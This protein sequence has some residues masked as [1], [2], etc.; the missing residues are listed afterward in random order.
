MRLSVLFVLTALILASCGGGSS[1][2]TQ[3]PIGPQ[4]QPPPSAPPTT[5]PRAR[6]SAVRSATDW[7]YW[8][9]SP[10][11]QSPTGGIVIGPGIVATELNEDN[12]HD[13]I[14][15][16]AH[17]G[18][19]TGYG[20]FRNGV[21]R[22]QMFTYLSEDAAYQ[23]GRLLR[24]GNEPPTV[25]VATGA[26]AG[27]IA[28]TRAVVGLINSALPQRWQL[29]FSSQ[30]VPAAESPQNGGIVV[31]FS[32]ARTWPHRHDDNTLGLADW[33]YES[34]GEITA[35]RVW[36]DPARNRTQ[37]QRM[38]VLAHEMLHALGRGHAD[39][40]RFP[41]TITHESLND[42]RHVKG[43][44]LH[45]LDNEALLAV[46]SRMRPGTP[47]HL[48]SRDL[49]PWESESFNV[50]AV[51]PPLYGGD[52]DDLDAHLPGLVMFGASERN[53]AVRPWALGHPFPDA[54][55]ANSRLTGSATWTGRL[56][57]LTTRSEPLAGAAGMTID[58][59][60]LQGDLSFSGLETWGENR[61]P[62]AI[63]TGARWGDGDLD[64]EIQVRGNGFHRVAG[65]GSDTGRVEGVFVGRTHERM[66]GIVDRYDM[67][68]GFGGTRQ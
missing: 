29:R 54:T 68:A 15:G 44:I 63:G 47:A 67:S 2:L 9:N 27:Q 33:Q 60:T 18:F 19:V 13:I 14:D 12:A 58:I 1:S 59:A 25:Y 43:Y 28:E 50:L 40:R 66:V 6:Y 61:P 20:R 31:R 65:S 62:G 34:T 41:Y 3:R 24:W 11:M 55:L 22:F 5:V 38:E 35:A 16:P 51:A 39:A 49:G 37:Q 10:I 53:G 42:E 8:W 52:P 45:Q 64:Y 17:D 46:Y 21:G 32:A 26:T 36:L 23:G 48:V 30:P 57:G 4:T 56:L 7:R